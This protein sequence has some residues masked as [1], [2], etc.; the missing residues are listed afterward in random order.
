MY[1]KMLTKLAEFVVFFVPPKLAGL[2]LAETVLYC[3]ATSLAVSDAAQK[4]GGNS[5]Q[6]ICKDVGTTNVISPFIDN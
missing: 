5:I 1:L 2:V 4:E 6:P 3:V